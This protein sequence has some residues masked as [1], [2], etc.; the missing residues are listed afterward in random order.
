MPCYLSHFLQPFQSSQFVIGGL[1]RGAGDTISTTIITLITV[2]GIRT[3]LGLLFINEL[4]LGLIGA[5]CAIAADQSLRSLLYLLRYN[6]GKWKTI[7][8]L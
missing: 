2:V 3:L 6:Q 4:H 5:W 8:L 7:K 1:L